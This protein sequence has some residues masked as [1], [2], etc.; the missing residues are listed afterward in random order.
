MKKN[1]IRG[2]IVIVLVA[3]IFYGYFPIVLIA[4]VAIL[5]QT[6]S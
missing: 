1:L 6:D 4:S 3:S 2:T 5:V